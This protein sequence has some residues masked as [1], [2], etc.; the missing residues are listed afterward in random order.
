MHCGEFA[1][2]ETVLQDALSKAAGDADTL[3][4][5]I[6]VCQHLRRPED[7]VKRYL[8]QLQ[9]KHPGHQLVETLATFD[10]AFERVATTLAK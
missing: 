5:L 9:S 7:V 10:G 4:N 1:E 6:V 8:M 3:A 2:A